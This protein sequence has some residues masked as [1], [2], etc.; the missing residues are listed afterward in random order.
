[1]QLLRLL[2]LAVLLGR[3]TPLCRLRDSAHVPELAQDGDFV[4]G[5]IFSFRTGQDYVIDTFRHIPEAR[6]CKK[7]AVQ[8]LYSNDLCVICDVFQTLICNFI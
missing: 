3:G 2:L 5:G 8:S 6:K 7:Y 1:M 4:I